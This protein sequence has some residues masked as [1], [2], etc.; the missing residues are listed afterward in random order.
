MLKFQGFEFQWFVDG[1]SWL[2]DSIA[3]SGL[4]QWYNSPDQSWATVYMSAAAKGTDPVY[5]QCALRG[6][7][8]LPYATTDLIWE[9][10]GQWLTLR[11]AQGSVAPVT[12]SSQC[13]SNEQLLCRGSESHFYYIALLAI[14]FELGSWAITDCCKVTWKSYLPF[15]SKETAIHYA[16]FKAT[17]IHIL[18]VTGQHDC[19]SRNVYDLDFY[20]RTLFWAVLLLNRWKHRFPSLNLLQ[21]KNHTMKT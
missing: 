15:T 14:C 3:S 18:K 16:W 12:L 5:L 7:I 11:W 17:W 19:R 10:Y 20:I 8:I 21:T 4:T 9:L 2:C 6:T 13:S 1:S